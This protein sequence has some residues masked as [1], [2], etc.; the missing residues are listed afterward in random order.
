MGNFTVTKS[1]PGTTVVRF[2][3]TDTATLLTTSKMI[4]SIIMDAVE[5]FVAAERADLITNGDL[6]IVEGVERIHSI[7]AL[8]FDFEN[9][10]ADLTLTSTSSIATTGDITAA[11]PYADI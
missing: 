9:K 1:H 11:V 5:Q 4:R 8:A 6:A 3:V 7:P 2:A 10:R